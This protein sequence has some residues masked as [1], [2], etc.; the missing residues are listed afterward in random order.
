MDPSRRPAVPDAMTIEAA[1]R[2]SAPLARLR[3]RLRDS[4]ARYAAIRPLLPA[5]MAAHVKPGPVDDEGWTLLAANPAVAAKLRHLEP[6]LR[7][8]LTRAGWNGQ[9]IRIKVLTG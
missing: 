2:G 5:M 1:L 9:A 4:E 6:R 7:A 3:E 8:A